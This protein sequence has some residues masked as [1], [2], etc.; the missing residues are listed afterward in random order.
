MD[1]AIQAVVKQ[2]RDELAALYG[3]RLAQM[4]LFG[5][6]ARGDAQAG[7]DIDL[8]IV[9]KGPVHPGR[10][11]ARVGKITAALSLANDVVISC[12]FVSAERYAAEGTPLLLNARREGVP[13]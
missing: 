2:A 13:V 6:Q 8:L 9:L 4:V 7:S 11:I 5:S 10:E 1:A 3:D 12:T